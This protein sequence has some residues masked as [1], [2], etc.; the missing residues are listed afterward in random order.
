MPI[1]QKLKNISNSQGFSLLI[2]IAGVA[3]IGSMIGLF[4][5]K[6][7]QVSSSKNVN[8]MA[9]NVAPE[10]LTVEA[11]TAF[12]TCFGSSRSSWIVGEKTKSLVTS[13]STDFGP[14]C[15]KIESVRT[16]V[17]RR[18]VKTTTVGNC[19]TPTSPLMSKLTCTNTNVTE[20]NRETFDVEVIV[21]LSPDGIGNKI[22]TISVNNTAPISWTTIG[23]IKTYY[24]KDIILK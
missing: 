14:E 21:T 18:P 17:L 3:V 16:N 19:D 22:Q 5:L 11:G 6:N 1:I 7:Q 23:K 13:V 12:T 20:K 4:L 9:E 10:Q 2:V 15:K 8:Q 24:F